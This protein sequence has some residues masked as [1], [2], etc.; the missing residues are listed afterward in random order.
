MTWYVVCNWRMTLLTAL[1]QFHL[2]LIQSLLLSSTYQNATVCKRHTTLTTTVTC[3]NNN[4]ILWSHEN[5]TTLHYLWPALTLQTA[6][7]KNKVNKLIYGIRYEI[8]QNWKYFKKK[9]PFIVVI[10][11][12]T[13]LYELKLMVT[14]EV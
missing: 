7:N 2:W 14:S 1:F 4:Q 9:L 12:K 6:V 5:A 3:P 11:F 8:I 13:K 10:N